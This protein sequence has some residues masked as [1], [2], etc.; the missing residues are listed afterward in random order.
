MKRSS[1]VPLVL[2]TAFAAAM[3]ACRQKTTRYCVDSNNIVVKNDQCRDEQHAA[4]GFPYHWYYGGA[5]GYVAPGTRISGGST[6][7]PSGGF[8]SP[9][10]SETSRGAIGEAGEAASG[11]AAG[12]AG[13]GE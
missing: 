3:A 2:L 11:H 13:A 6:T 7:P 8:A 4:A 9:T 1:A 10:E 5:S 12:E